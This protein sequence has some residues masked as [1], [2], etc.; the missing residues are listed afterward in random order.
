MHGSKIIN[1]ST[2]GQ[3]TP[4][5]QSGG[6]DDYHCVVVNPHVTADSFIIGDR[7]VPES[8]EVHHA[9]LFAVPP[10]EVAA[11]EQAD[12]G[13]KGWSCFGEDPLQLQGTDGTPWLAV[14]APG[15]GVD[16]VPKG[17]G[18]TFS[19]GS[20]L[21]VQT[22]YNLLAGDKPVQSHLQLQLVPATDHLQPLQTDLFAAPPDIPCPAGVH[23]KLCNRTASLAEESK[24]FGPEVVQTAEG[25]EQQCGR[26]PSDP[27]EGDSTTCSEPAGFDGTLLRVMPH[28]HLLGVAYRLVLN[29]GKPDQK[30]LLNVPNYNFDY[31]KWYAIAPTKIVPGDTL[32]ETCTWN[33]RLRQE[34]PQLR[35]LPPQFIVWGWGSSQEMCLGILDYVNS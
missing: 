19:K 16:V 1:L 5:A 27:P 8:P 10:S 9:V 15:H 30:V 33:P 17:T 7:F 13:G 6:T 28:M 14:W 34:L 29:P 20:L 25:L 18:V 32:E 22:H 35:K 4:H 2:P 23:G 26:N 31:Q 24:L 12:A 11:A 3:Y 21:I